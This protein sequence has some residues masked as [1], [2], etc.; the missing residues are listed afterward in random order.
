ML[1]PVLSHPPPVRAA[2]LNSYNV[3]IITKRTHGAASNAVF[4]GFAAS[5]LETNKFVYYY[6]N[7][8]YEKQQ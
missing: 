1:Q 7:K 2:V 8:A 6:L 3:F 5:H 4:S